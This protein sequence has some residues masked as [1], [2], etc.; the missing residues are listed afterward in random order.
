MDKFEIEI[1]T[2]MTVTTQDIDDI[3][4]AALEGGI[5][6][7]CNAA[8]VVG[9]YLGEFASDQISRG[10][11]LRL[12][13]A[14]S[15][16]VYNLTLDGVLRGIQ[17]AYEGHWFSEYGWCDGNTID[18]CQVDADV[19]DAIVQLALFDDVIFG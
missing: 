4:V 2:K 17:K 11:M 6:Y 3:M 10:G 19:A 9:D 5:N 13:D 7:W 18:A 16:D 8:E 1:T 12:Y 14:E 15:N